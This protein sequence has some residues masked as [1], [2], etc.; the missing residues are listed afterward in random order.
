[1]KKQELKDLADPVPAM[2]DGEPNDALRLISRI[3]GLQFMIFRENDWKFTKYPLSTRQDHET[4]IRCFYPKRELSK[5]VLERKYYAFKTVLR[6]VEEWAAAR[7]EWRPIGARAGSHSP[8]A[9]QA[10][11][12]E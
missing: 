6:N 4:Y 5:P 8:A 7:G 11:L 2:V 3:E 10:L 1:M 12:A 9:V